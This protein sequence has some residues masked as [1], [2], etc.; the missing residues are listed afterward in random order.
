M[1]NK[2]ER[3]KDCQAKTNGCCRKTAT[4]VILKDDPRPI[5][6]AE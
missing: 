3:R 2:P 6:R 1:K 4:A 5:S